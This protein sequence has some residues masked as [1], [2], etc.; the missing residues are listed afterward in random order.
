MRFS[1]EYADRPTIF[2]ETQIAKLRQ[3]VFNSKI[4]SRNKLVMSDQNSA[5]KQQKK[6]TKKNNTY[7]CLYKSEAVYL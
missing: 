7:N 1:I 3:N 6:T 2:P 4:I 5:K